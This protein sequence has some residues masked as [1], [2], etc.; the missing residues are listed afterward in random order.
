MER[1]PDPS[2]V[3]AS[4]AEPEVPTTKGGPACPNWSACFS[5]RYAAALPWAG[6][7]PCLA[8]IAGFPAALRWTSL[9]RTEVDLNTR[10]LTG[11]PGV[12]R[13]DTVGLA[14]IGNRTIKGGGKEVAVKYMALVHHAEVM[15][16]AE[17]RRPPIP[18]P[19]S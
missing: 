5:K 18:K 6:C 1:L 2:R 14:L 10:T 12:A 13:T 15:H 8:P 16:D 11:D 9:T 4:I 7:S 19:S 3:P 17:P